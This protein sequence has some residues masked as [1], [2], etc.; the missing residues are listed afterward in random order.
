MTPLQINCHG[1]PVTEGIE[2]HVTSKIT[3]LQ[4]FFSNITKVHVI[5]KHEGV[6]YVAEAELHAAGN[7]HNNLF[8]KAK[9][10]D[11]YKSIDALE[12]K[13]EVIVKKHHDKMKDL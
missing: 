8:A 6:E 10:D 9:S 12:K 2:E 7:N 3:K 11:L 13:L 1:F 4:K 5:L